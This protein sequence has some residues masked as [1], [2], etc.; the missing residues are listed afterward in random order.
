VLERS[1]TGVL[2]LHEAGVDHS[3]PRFAARSEQGGRRQSVLVPVSFSS[4]S[5]GAIDLAF[6]LA[7]RLDLDLHLLH[8]EPSRVSAD[9]PGTALAVEE[10]RRLHELVPADLR[11]RAQVH[12]ATGDPAREIAAVAERLDA[13][14]IVMGEHARVSL[15]RWFTRDTGR[16]V[17]HRAHCPVWYVPG[18]APADGFR[19]R[20]F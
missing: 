12:V 2:A 17:L 15:R 6:A 9:E 13:S 14:L 20:G 5:T 4:T 18:P 8:V 11:A 3:A 1:T 19:E 7:R 16:A 10:R